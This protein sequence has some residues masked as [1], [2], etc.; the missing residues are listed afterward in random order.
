MGKLEKRVEDRIRRTRLNKAIIGTIATAGVI[1]VGLVAPNAFSVL[2]A[3]KL[4][5]QQRYR[6][7]TILG[8]MVQKGYAR[9]E[10]SDG[11]PYVR[12]T[13]KGERF[14]SL[15][16]EGKLGPNKSLKWDGKWRIVTYDVRGKASTT[17][18]RIR[19][20]LQSWGFQLLHQSLWVSPYDCEDLVFLLK[21]EFKLGK[22]LLYVI[23][24]EIEMDSTLRNQF[25]LPL[26][27]K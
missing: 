23:A 2:G 5:P 3:T 19:E 17:R 10:R 24:E 18:A 15:M 7:K 16:H 4:L 8:R 9:V 25:G 1:A 14:A 22:G 26:K 11:K 12:L 20:L 27:K 21:Q 13:E 6:V